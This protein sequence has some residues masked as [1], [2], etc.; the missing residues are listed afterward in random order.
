M[1]RFLAEQELFIKSTNSE[2]LE[3]HQVK[4]GILDKLE[5]P[6][7]HIGPWGNDE[8]IRQTAKRVRVA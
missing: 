3:E 4:V 6:D 8:H 2:I 7:A 5:F 1:K